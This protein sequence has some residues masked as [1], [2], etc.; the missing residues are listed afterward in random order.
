MLQPLPISTFGDIAAIGRADLLPPLLPLHRDR[1]HAAVARLFTSART[2]APSPRT[3]GELLNCA[4]P[5]LTL[6]VHSALKYRAA[7]AVDEGR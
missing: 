5:E 4:W 3:A 6:S 7:N 1:H 2:G